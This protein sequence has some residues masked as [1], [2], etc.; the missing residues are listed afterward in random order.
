MAGGDSL[1]TVKQA[2]IGGK[3]VLESNNILLQSN[4]QKEYAAFGKEL[5]TYKGIQEKID[6]LMEQ[7]KAIEASQANATQALDIL[8]MFKEA[9][10]N[11]VLP[12]D[13]DAY[14]QQ[15]SIQDQT[16]MISLFVSNALKLIDPPTL[17]LESE[18]LLT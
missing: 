14:D 6:P 15:A 3:A 10:E 12:S 17:I 2:L 5:E 13:I 18:T 4:L 1:S 8:N 9:G 11:F 16:D 7:F